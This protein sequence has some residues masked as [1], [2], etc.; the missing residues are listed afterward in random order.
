[1]R[2]EIRVACRDQQW[3]VRIG[4]DGAPFLETSRE[5]AI[6][7]AIDLAVQMVAA[8]ARPTVAL[9]LE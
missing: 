5:S 3:E 8:V 9:V 1:M 2:T 7:H 4:G 6:A